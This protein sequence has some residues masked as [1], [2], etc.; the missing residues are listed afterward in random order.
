[1]S[2]FWRIFGLN[3]LVLGTATALLLLAPIRVSVPVLLTE[4]VI[5]VGGLAVMLVANAALLR[6]GLAP[7]GRLTRLMRTV[8]LLRPGQRL[9]VPGAR[10]GDPGGDP[11]AHVTGDIAGGKDGGSGRG[12]RGRGE[13]AE[14]IRT[15]N[16][17][18]DRL[19]HERATSS[20]QALM[21][22]EA[23]RRRIAQELHDEVGQGM[24]AILLVLKRAAEEAPEPL[25]EELQQ[26]QE[27]T[28]ESLD[29]V[30]RLVRRLRPGVL[31]DLGLISALTSL[32][33]DFATH[34]GVRVV[35]RFD[36]DLPVLDRETELVLYRV[37]Q[38][39]LTN[40][41]RHAD[42]GRVEVTLRRVGAAVTLE[43]A[44]DGRGVGAAHEGAGIRGMRER[45]LLAGATL[46]IASTS[47]TGTRIRLT[48]PVPRK[49]FST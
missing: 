37:A 21:A 24:T 10:L 42:A 45:A 19:E 23:E 27:I 32:T 48:T 11:D 44:D 18:L 30:R 14:L 17:M 49:Q 29:E 39:S 3:A 47:R 16:A 43:I 35:R 38:E 4:A 9:P 25:R 20:A 26:V 22:Q 7:L 41:A 40:A 13:V 5:L 1:M 8:D 31:E 15:F 2:L 6:W 34:T 12:G 46:D 28:R 33:Q 36:S